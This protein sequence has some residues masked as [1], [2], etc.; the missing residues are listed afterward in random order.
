M[1]L[2]DREKEF[3]EHQANIFWSL[4]EFG[5]K[6]PAAGEHLSKLQYK[7]W[8]ILKSQK[9]SH[10]FFTIYA[11]PQIVLICYY[12]DMGNKSQPQI[13]LTMFLFFGKSQPQC[14]Y[15]FVLIKKSV[16]LIFLETEPHILINII[17]IKNKMCISLIK[18]HSKFYKPPLIFI[19]WFVYDNINGRQC[20]RRNEQTSEICIEVYTLQT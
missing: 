10:C 15:K 7:K 20:A 5:Q 16:F 9:F 14:S 6:M 18:I 3:G 17:L 2:Y 8:I 1:Q 4:T 11:Q 12:F 19:H 13:V